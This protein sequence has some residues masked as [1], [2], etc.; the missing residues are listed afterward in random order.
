MEIGGR[1]AFSLLVFIGGRV[2]I[3]DCPGGRV[4]C[5][6]DNV[7]HLKSNCPQ[8]PQYFGLNWRRAGKSR[9][10]V[11]KVDNVDNP[12]LRAGL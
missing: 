4:A 11:D 3:M 10:I 7:D 12:F 8:C 9:V 6:V 2:D 1:V 5:I